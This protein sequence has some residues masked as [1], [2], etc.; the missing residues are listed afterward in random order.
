MRKFLTLVIYSCLFAISVSAQETATIGG[1]KYYFD[2]GEATIMVQPRALSGNITIPEKVIYNK[3]DYKVTKIESQ[4]FQ[5]TSITSITLPGSITTLKKDCFSRCLNLKSVNLSNGITTLEDRCFESCTNLIDIIFSNTIISLGEEC[6][7]DCTSLTNI[8]LPN[9][10]ISLGEACFD[11]CT[12]LTNIILPNSIKTLGDECFTSCSS[13]KEITLPNSIT[14]LPGA[15]FWYC[16]SLTNIILPNS[17]TTLRESCF[18]ACSELTNI[19]LSKNITFIGY[20]CF[21]SCKS[22]I[23][24]ECFWSKLDDISTD[25]KAF[26]NIF[27]EAKLYVPT[28]ATAIYQAKKPWSNFKYIVEEGSTPATKQCT[29]PT[30]SYSDKKL[31]FTSTTTGAQYHYTI[32]DDDIKTDAY[33]ENGTVSLTATYDISVYASAN[34]YTN[35][36]KAMAKL[37]FINAGLENITGISTAKQR[38]ILIQSDNDFLTVSG[39]NDNESVSL[40]NVSGVQLDNV[41]ATSGTATFNVNKTD[42]VVIV[43]IGNESIKVKI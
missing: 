34:D 37:Y 38:G 23:K 3:I 1:I 7:K 18:Q 17:V 10:I 20:D 30:I 9:T 6:F 19:T 33:S 22:L 25:E 27:S 36:E 35:S 32:I 41:K 8:I 28:G 29:T 13:L 15:C 11:N 4:A 31:S 2:N 39:L 40:Y 21:L 14:I 24:V 42:E 43:K 26:E 5:S 12:S 16:S